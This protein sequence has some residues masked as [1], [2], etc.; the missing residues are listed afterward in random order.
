MA[1]GNIVTGLDI[2]THSIKA[3]AVHRNK[4]SWEVLSYAEVPSFGL[5][6]GAV[7]N[8][9]ETSKNNKKKRKTT[10]QSSSTKD[11]RLSAH[12]PDVTSN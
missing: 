12:R 1:R 7:V 8:A 9:E 10:G 5:R 2:G 11:K 6:K 4:N 3:L